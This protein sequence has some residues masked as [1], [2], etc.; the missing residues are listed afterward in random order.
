MKQLLIT[1]GIIT[2]VFVLQL[3]FPEQ[4]LTYTGGPPTAN[5][6]S[7]G[8]GDNCTS[9]HSGTA[10]LT[11]GL[12]TSTVPVAG[13]DSDSTYTISVS[14]TAAGKSKF[15]FQASPQSLAGGKMGTIIVTNS[16]T[17]QLAGAGKYIHQRSAGTSGAGGKAWTFDWIPPPTGSGD[18]KFYTA[19]NVTNSNGLSSGDITHVSSLEIIENPANVPATNAMDD[20]AT[21][22]ENSNV[23][24]EV[25]DNDV[26][27]GGNPLV[28]TIVSQP[29]NGFAIILDDDS[30]Y[31]VPNPGFN[32]SDM[33]VYSICDNSTPALCDTALIVIT[34]TPLVS[35]DER[36]GLLKIGV[37]PNPSSE[38]LFIT[39]EE[40]IAGKVRIRD[41]MGNFVEVKESRDGEHR[42]IDVSEYPGGI[43]LLEIDGMAPAKFLVI[44]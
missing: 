12:I 39:G 22:I 16:V 30:I 17:T 24:I 37:Y 40:K 19:V 35:L 4:G 3:G 33:I 10:Q 31:Y 25:Q 41:L 14:I 42:V 5:T 28:T 1:A 9:C 7:P 11:P 2:T 43:Y 44:R 32:G 21:V 15:G 29:S 20:A 23:I 18:L 6:G 36:D 8:D 13:Y 27:N 38:Y 34:V 26:S